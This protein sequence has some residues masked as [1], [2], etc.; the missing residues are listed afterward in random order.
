MAKRNRHPRHSETK[1]KKPEGR[2]NVAWWRRILKV[3]PGILVSLVL[4]FLFSRLSALH[5]VQTVV[6]DTMM[7]IAPPPADSEVAIVEI[8]NDDYK[9]LF[10]GESPLD[11]GCLQELL[12]AIARSNPKI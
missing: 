5:K 10:G 8:T 12:N 2:G 3:L 11:P 9:K 6:S 7:R 4:I 1:K